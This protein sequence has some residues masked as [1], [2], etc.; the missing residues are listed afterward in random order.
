[1]DEWQEFAKKELEREIFVQTYDDGFD[2]EAS[3]AYHRLVTEIYFYFFFLSKE[4]E[5]LF[6]ERLQKMWDMILHLVHGDGQIS[7]IGDNDSGRIFSLM[8]RDD[9]D[10]KYL[11]NLGAVQ[12]KRPDMAVIGWEHTSEILLLFGMSGWAYLNEN[13]SLRK[14]HLPQ[15]Q[16]G[17]SGLFALRKPGAALL[18]CAQSNGTQGVGNHTHNDKLAITLHIEGDD[19]FIDP[20]TIVYTPDPYLR[21]RMRSTRSHNTVMVDVTEQNK[22]DEKS[23]FTLGTDAKVTVEKFIP[24]VCLQATH[25]GYERLKD[26]V[27]HR[28]TLTA[29][30]DGVEWELLDELVGCDEHQLEWTYILGP[31]IRP[32]LV[33]PQQ[34]KF[35]GE[36]GFV[37]MVLPA[38]TFKTEII[39]WMVGPCYGKAAVT[40]AL[41]IDFQSKLPLKMSILLS[42]TRK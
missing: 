39:N 7:L 11:L 37:S 34:I 10:M 14:D 30:A 18:F 17:G 42:W 29:S 36:A 1:M 32:E 4:S 2:Y 19:F 26:P 12:F 23:L 20:G 16:R 8:T 21:N 6:V 41:K 40:K 9:A 15:T 5:P 33:S 35:Y 28:R 13:K 38:S 3:T 31:K 24:G 25:S 22:M 27:T